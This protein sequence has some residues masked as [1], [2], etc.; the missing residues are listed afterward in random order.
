[1]K[2]VFCSVLVIAILIAALMIPAS[3]A[4]NYY[5]EELEHEFI[6]ASS[7]QASYSYNIPHGIHGPA[8]LRYVENSSESAGYTIVNVPEGGTGNAHV[9]IFYHYFE[10]RRGN[11]STVE[12]GVITARAALEDYFYATRVTHSGNCRDGEDFTAW[13]YYFT[14][15]DHQYTAP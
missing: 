2:R 4:T 8:T 14:D 5:T 3:A 6:S 7:Q 11:S 1:M 9:G 12:Y 10:G 15:N 13:D